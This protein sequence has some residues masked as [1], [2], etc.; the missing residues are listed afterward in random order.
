MS[1]QSN[2][3]RFV[4]PLPAKPWTQAMAAFRSGEDTPS[5]YL[6]RCL[7]VIEERDEVVQA[8]VSV[9]SDGA[10]DA[11]AASTRRW[12]EGRPASLVDGLPVGVKDLLETRD[13]PTQMGCKAFEGNFPRRDN[14]AVLAL[15]SAGAVVVGKTVTTELGNIEPG[16]TTHPLDPS[17][18]PGGSSSGSAAA[19]GAGMVPA[20]VG[21]QVGG[22]I[23]RP[24]SFCGNWALKPS[25]G[26]INRGERQAT[27]MSTHG[28]HALDP[29]AMWSAMTAIARRVGGDPGRPALRGPDGLPEPSA[30]TGLVVL[31][32]DGWQ[33]T[34]EATRSLFT[35][36]V[37]QLKATPVAVRTR[38]D[39][40]KV[41]GL[42]SSIHG[43]GRLATEITAW[44]NHWSL[45][46]LVEQHPDGVSERGQQTLDIAA[47]VGVGGYDERL[48][49]REEVREAQMRAL[50]PGDVI[51]TLSSPGPAPVWSGDTPGQ[52]LEPF[53]T[54]NPVF[55]FPASLWG[56]PALTVPI[57]EVGGLPVGVQLVGA[58]GSDADLV[59][60]GL[61]LAQ[62][63]AAVAG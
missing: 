40:P 22:S 27:S 29:L 15:R 24:A 1:P 42:E 3:T 19:V 36:L 11:A 16:P 35:D 14:T 23:I 52:P 18:T 8:F 37:G 34:D 30:P 13:M 33:V 50:A 45:R 46:W 28:M 26:A 56:A 6:E 63:V 61:W 5:A 39:D 31:E 48:K 51:L 10:R 17:R 12:Q 43:A 21:T 54:G 62:Q 58:P 32:T 7:K 2:G 4:D 41:E 59:S 53:P 47:R 55:N 25:Q 20:A 60:A 38:R 44:E 49:F 9:N 57:L